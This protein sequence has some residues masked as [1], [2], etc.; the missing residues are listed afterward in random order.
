M[1]TALRDRMPQWCACA[2]VVSVGRVRMSCDE[3]ELRGWCSVRLLGGVTAGRAGRP[4]FRVRSR[5]VVSLPAIPCV[6]TNTLPT[7]S[8]Q[9]RRT[10]LGRTLLG[11]LRT[12]RSHR[13]GR[14]HESEPWERAHKL[15]S[16]MDGSHRRRGKRH[17]SRRR[18]WCHCSRCRHAE[19]HD[20]GRKRDW[21][22]RRIAGRGANWVGS[23]CAR[24]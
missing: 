18:I 2:F 19:Q 8:L 15:G 22:S 7:L 4:T 12:I 23:P 1:S 5:L 3:V 6:R 14:N 20:D 13:Q 16:A 21:H 9:Q 10:C 11:E 24:Q 17:N